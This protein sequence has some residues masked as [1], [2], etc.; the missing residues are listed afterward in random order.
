MIKIAAEHVGK[1]VR[2]QGVIPINGEEDED[3]I[4]GFGNHVG[5]ITKVDG[6][7][8]RFMTHEGESHLNVGMWRIM[9]VF[10]D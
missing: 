5:V 8:F 2:I 3:L 1:K 7:K 9:E 6:R 4:I 10:D